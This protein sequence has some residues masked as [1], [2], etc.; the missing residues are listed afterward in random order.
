MKLSA[1]IFD[2]DGLL[3]DTE[4]IARDAWQKAALDWG[5]RIENELYQKAIGKRI[6]DTKKILLNTFGIGFPFDEIRKR[7]QQYIEEYISQHG[8][9]KKPGLIKLLDL[10][11]TLSLLKAVGSSTEKKSVIRKLTLCGLIKRFDIMVCGDEVENGKPA[12]DI[13]LTTAER[14]HVPAEQCLV[15]EDSENG[16][17]AAHTAGMIPIM[18]PDL[19]QPSKKIAALTYKIFPTLD[20]VT[21]FLYT[22][23]IRL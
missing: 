11:D 9:P 14:L 5:Y 6:Q 10:I 12:P 15:L 22:W 23:S 2:M 17:N 16:I 18:V 13:F 1:V 19:I 8:I 21:T 3:M 20:E 4:R 7:K